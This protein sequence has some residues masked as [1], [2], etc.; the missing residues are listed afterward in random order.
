MSVYIIAEAGVNHNGSLE[1]AFALVEKAQEAAR[2]VQIDGLMERKP[3]ELL[4]RK[5]RFAI[6]PRRR[7]IKR[8]QRAVMF[9][10]LIW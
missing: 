3:G 8:R 9:R 2:L 4:F 10:S 1:T 5:I 7:P 6:R